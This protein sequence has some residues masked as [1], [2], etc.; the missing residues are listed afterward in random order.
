MTA[1]QWI[2]KEAK[3]LKKKY[4]KRFTT[5]K[6]YVAQ[7]SAIYASKHKGKSPVGKKKKTVGKL[8]STYKKKLAKKTYT[9]SKQTGPSKK[10]VDVTRKAK[11]PGKR[12][13]KT[14]KTYYEY[15]KNRSDKGM[16]YGIHKDTKSHN[17]NIR[18]VSGLFDTSVIKDLDGLK[19]Q[20]LKLA[21]KYHPDAGGTTIQFQELQKEYEKLLNNLLKGSSLSDEQKK[22]EI[23]IDEAIREVIN[24]LV[25]LESINIELIGKWL[26]ISGNTYPVR[27]TLKNAGLIFI[28]KD[29][30]PYWVYKGVE[31]AGRGKLTMDEI[32]NKYGV[33]KID[34][35]KIKRIGSLPKI[36]KVKLKSALLKLK[37]ALDKRPI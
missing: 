12:I 25:N 36:N 26:W 1:L 20:Y 27:N 9:S 4:P 35:P 5:W 7:A 23:V 11:K 16:F 8:S 19:K 34:A 29:D 22:N 18:V 24:Q 21:K 15:R 32:K 17:V 33:T 10:K 37:R 31:S 13:S 30:K 28:K 6:E 3:S 14:G 2:I